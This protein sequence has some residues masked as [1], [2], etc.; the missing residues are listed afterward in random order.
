MLAGYGGL[1]TAAFLAATIIP[2]QSE[3]VFLGL[4]ATGKYAAPI[5]LVVASVG[6]VL[7]SLFNW[8]LGRGIERFKDR[9]W[10]PVK[11]HTL[12]KAQGWYIKY[13]RLSLLLSWV[14]II[15]DPL[16]VAA[17][18]MR[19]KIVLFIFLV[20]LAKTTRYAVLYLAFRGIL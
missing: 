19:E 10:F 3:A 18:V 4:L 8:W 16:T 6:N 5:L 11:R 1:F 2:A 12:E 14:P 13:G 7:G 17:G 20:T 9:K 15:G